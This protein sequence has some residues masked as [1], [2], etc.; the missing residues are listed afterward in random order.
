MKV[1]ARL[2]TCV[3]LFPQEP[4]PLVLRPDRREVVVP[5]RTER[6]EVW[7]ERGSDGVVRTF[8]RVALD[9]VSFSAPRLTPVELELRYQRFD[10]RRASPALPARLRAGPAN[11][12]FIV[13]Y[14]TLGLEAYRAALR[15]QGAR[16]EF[17]LPNDANVVTLAP[18][19]VEAVRALPFVRAV[20]PF[21]PAY[22]LEEPLLEGVL[23]ER[24]GA[25]RVNVV[26]TRIG[27]EDTVVPWIR[28]RGG[29]L[30]SVSRETRTVVAELGHERLAE[31]AG[32]DGV[33]WIDRAGPV[34]FCMDVAREFHGTNELEARYGLTGTGV[35]VEVLDAG[36]DLRHP[37]LADNVLLHGVNDPDL[38]SEHGTHVSGI[39]TGD[40][41]G[42]PLARGIAPDALLV[43]AD[44]DQGLQ[45]G[46]RLE[47]TRQLA[48][49]SGPYR[50]LIQSNSWATDPETRHYNSI[51]RQLDQVLFEVPRFITLQAMGNGG[52]SVTFG[53]AWAKNS[54]SVGA[55]NHENTLSDQ[56][57]V[58]NLSGRRGPAAD[59][60]IKPDVASFYDQI[61]CTDMVGSDGRTPGDYFGGFFG[62]SAA[63]PIVAG[64]MALIFE[65]WHLG[66]FGNPHAGATV[67]DNAPN[68]STAKALLIQ[69]AKQ[70]SFAG[71]DHDRTRVHQGWGRPDMRVLLESLGRMFVI[72]ESDVLGLLEERDY[73][74][75]VA[76]GERELVATLVFREPPGTVGAALSRIN[77]LDLTVTSPTGLRYHGNHGL[78]ASMTS[79][80][81][82]AP[83]TVDPVENVILSAPEPGR[84]RVTVR[85]SEL[86]E[87][88]HL[89]TAALDADFALVVR[90][91]V[92]VPAEAPEA[93]LD[94]RGR[95]T[96][97][98]ARLTFRDT[99]NAETGFELLRSSEGG[100]FQPRARL[101]A[102]STVFIDADVVPGRT[103]AY[104]VRA[105]NHVGPS[106]WSNT[107]V[108]RTFHAES[109]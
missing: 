48:D 43:V 54:I 16:V 49:P 71:L 10:P 40:G 1:L 78:S 63:T 79:L 66:M 104:R 80:P 18:E 101:P 33:Q 8:S 75:D 14:W 5:G 91:G 77:D 56:D 85:V 105:V 27:D 58:W 22:K 103:Y 98:G 65:M 12:L 34:V 59:G 38:F 90:G 44:I 108:L 70:W 93:P 3:A 82:G 21:H 28:A 107:L 87:D 35:A 13:Q 88:N 95:A 6:G 57:D 20:V 2:L 94:L 25:L 86:N 67:F 9:G 55:L 23:A 99:S 83:N 68:N 74:L 46:S 89:E 50:C 37:D 32:L 51:S 76:P 96:G 30:V 36:C 72:D 19:D 106:G 64:H 39:L 60:R 41:L 69:A 73:W 81:G 109:R 42:N 100:P 102:D 15:A 4:D 62:T 11:R 26:L 97:Q 61:L 31:L 7:S 29:A 84:W 53:E 45:G 17:F 47:H 24:S 52:G 92:R